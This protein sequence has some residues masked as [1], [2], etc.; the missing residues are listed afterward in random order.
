MNNAF[1]LSVWWTLIVLG[2]FLLF[3]W[4]KKLHKKTRN[5]SLD[6]QIT[7]LMYEQH[8]ALVA[9]HWK[10]FDQQ[11][12]EETFFFSKKKFLLWHPTKFNKLLFLEKGKEDILFLNGL[13]R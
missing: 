1:V 8:K 12:I 3:F 5:N 13:K 4:Y 6:M 7:D 9:L 10:L 2:L 11:K